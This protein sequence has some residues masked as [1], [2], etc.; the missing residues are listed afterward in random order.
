MCLFPG[1]AVTKYHQPGGLKQQKFAVS[2]FKRLEIHNQGVSRAMIPLTPAGE[3][4]SWT[5]DPG[6]GHQS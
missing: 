4:P 5:P 2:Q 6:G 1:T 3:Y